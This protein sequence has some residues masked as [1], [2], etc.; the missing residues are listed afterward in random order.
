MTHRTN[1]PNFYNLNYIIADYS[2]NIIYEER[3]TRTL[4]S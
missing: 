2:K 3:T 4:Q 1:E